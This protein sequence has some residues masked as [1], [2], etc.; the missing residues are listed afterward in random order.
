[1][2][3]GSNKGK[4]LNENM[5]RNFGMTS[6]EGFRK[7]L[8]LMRL[9]EEP[10]GGAHRDHRITAQQIKA[11]LLENIRDL[12]KKSMTALLQKRYD[13]Y[14]SIGVFTMVKTSV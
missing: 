14:S 7:A 4:N 5:E 2:L 1:M 3:I 12:K 11:A 13:K 8:R 9:A 10:L 6:Q